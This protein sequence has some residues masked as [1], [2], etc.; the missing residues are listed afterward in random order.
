MGLS[1]LALSVIEDPAENGRYHWLLQPH[2]AGDAGYAVSEL[3]FAS[4]AEATSPN[5]EVDPMPAAA[6]G[7][8]NAKLTRSFAWSS[9]WQARAAASS[10]RQRRADRALSP[11]AKGLGRPQI[12]TLTGAL[13]GATTTPQ[14]LK[15]STFMA[16][17]SDCRAFQ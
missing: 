6:G 12:A 8:R 3:S 16:L 10:R 15:P 13:H 2:S 5:L 11:N 14:G 7:A 4:A 17:P 9:T 1:H